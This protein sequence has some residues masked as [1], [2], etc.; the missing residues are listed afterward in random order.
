[1]YGLKR[2]AVVFTAGF[3]MAAQEP[4]TVTFLSEYDPDTP[5][6]PVTRQI[7]KLAQR[8]PQLDPRKWGGLTLPGGGGRAPFML[9]M[10]GR[11]AP[12]LYFCWFHIM[13]HDIEQGFMHPLNELIGEDRDG[14]GQISDAE[15]IWPGWKRHETN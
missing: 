13:R 2:L 9:S 1:M 5:E 4:V 12:D 7:L 11:T 8:E 14:D 6:G 15:A 3:A 10:A